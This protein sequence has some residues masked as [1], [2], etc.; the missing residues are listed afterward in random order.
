MKMNQF[1]ISATRILKKCMK[2]NTR[3]E[4]KWKNQG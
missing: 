1:D 4:V 3:Q 2:L